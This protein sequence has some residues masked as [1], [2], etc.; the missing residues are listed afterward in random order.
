MKLMKYRDEL[1]ERK[2]KMVDKAFAFLDKDGTGQL[3]V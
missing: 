3:N 2:K 1:T